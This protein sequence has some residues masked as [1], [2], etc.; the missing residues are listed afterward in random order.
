MTK[1]QTQPNAEEQHSGKVENDHNKVG[2][3]ETTQLNQ[4]HRTPLS[5]SDRESNIGGDNQTQSRRKPGKR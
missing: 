3:Q 1:N 5:R 2:H 4:G